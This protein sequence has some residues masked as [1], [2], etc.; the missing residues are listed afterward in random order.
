MSG[1]LDRLAA[2]RSGI[3]ARRHLLTTGWSPSA[4]HRAVHRGQLFPLVPGVFRVAGAPWSRSAAQHA[5]LLIAGEEAHLAR[6]SAAEVHGFGERHHGPIEVLLPRGT[7]RPAGRSDL[8]RVRHTRSLPEADRTAKAG[9]ALTAP[10]RTLLDLAATTGVERLAEVAAGALR[11]GA[12]TPP[13]FDAVIARRLNASG[14][15]R[16]RAAL[17]LLGS[18][19]VHTRSGVEIAAF[20]ALVKGGLP[21]PALAHRIHDAYGRFIAEVDL[22]YPE[23]KLAI[24][25]DGYRWHSTPAQ[26]RADEERQNRLILAGWTV[27][28]FSA[29]EVRRN[30]AALVTTVSRYLTSAAAIP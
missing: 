29:A 8:V 3:V 30:P 23:L 13:D 17:A 6:W 24:E 4:I 10:A 12:C 26:K 14:R 20:Q 9:L 1:T 21:R 27:L 2:A 5:A 25:I 11:T 22:A 19:G 16:L 18:D 15:G 28:R 7:G